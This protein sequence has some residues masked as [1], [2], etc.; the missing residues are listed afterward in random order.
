MLEIFSYLK[1]RSEHG[2]SAIEKSYVK[3]LEHFATQYRR[4]GGAFHLLESLGTLRRGPID[5]LFLGVRFSSLILSMTPKHRVGVVVQGQNDLSWCLRHR[6]TPVLAWKWRARLHKAYDAA[7]GAGNAEDILETIVE[8]IAAALASFGPRALVL[9]NDSL[10]LERAFILATRKLGIPSMTI[11]DGIFQKAAAPHVLHGRFTDYML[12][13]GE[14]FKQMY[15]DKAFLPEERVHVLGYPYP[16]EFQKS[17]LEGAPAVPT[18][19]FL[20]QPWESYDESLREPKTAMLH[21]VAEACR[22]LDLPLMYRPHPLERR[23]GLPT[24]PGLEVTSVGEGLEDAL[25]KYTIFFSVNSTAL[26][27]AAL[28][29]KVAAQILEAHFPSDDFK[30]LGVCHSLENNVDTIQEFLCRMREKPI[31]FPLNS[32]YID[33]MDSPGERLDELLSSLLKDAG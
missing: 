27:E 26:V 19:C 15:V 23:H 1:T 25:E 5:L 2:E 10:F 6:I 30:A 17:K 21:N 4:Y 29:G 11:Q 32:G 16:F 22:A 3:Q 9:E 14:F 13:W 33:L 31:P 18:V 28:R 7:H 12:V 24:I 20:G 8:D